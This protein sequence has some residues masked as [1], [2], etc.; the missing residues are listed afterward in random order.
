MPEPTLGGGNKTLEHMLRTHNIDGE[1]SQ[2]DWTKW[3]PW[4]SPGTAGKGNPDFSPCGVNS[5]SVP[6][7]LPPT[8]AN[9]VPDGI[10]G[11]K[12]PQLPKSEWGTWKAG[13]VVE[14]EWAIY[15]N[16]AGTIPTKQSSTSSHSHPF[17]R[18]VQLSAV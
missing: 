15:A 10:S 6:G 13:S 8:T 17:C 11:T 12:L 16:H 7:E 14:A 4:R 18:W 1:S 2:G 5:G 9:D 3:L